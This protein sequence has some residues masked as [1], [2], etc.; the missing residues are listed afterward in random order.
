MQTFLNKTALVALMGVLLL[1]GCQSGQDARK[2]P[3]RV[4]AE[5]KRIVQEGLVALT[6][7]VTLH[8]YRG[9]ENERQGEEAQALIDFMAETSP[10]ILVVNSEF[11]DASRAE[12]EVDSGPVVEMKGRAKGIMRY[13]GF[14]ERKEVAPFVDS[15]LV[16]SG[17]PIKLSPDVRSFLTGLKQEVV[18]RIFT[19]PD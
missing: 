8:L 5:A 9:G 18:V 2:P 13:Y 10:N 19:T 12:L 7:P 1:T 6:S 16:A 4:S 14:P 11:T 17:G 15:I 3:V